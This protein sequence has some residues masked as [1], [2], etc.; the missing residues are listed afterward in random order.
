MLKTDELK[1]LYRGLSGGSALDIAELN[2]RNFRFVETS[3]EDSPEYQLFSSEVN[4]LDLSINA[5]EN[6]LMYADLEHEGRGIS[7]FQIDMPR[8]Y[9]RL[10]G[11]NNPRDLFSYTEMAEDERGL[12]ESILKGSQDTFR[13]R[14]DDNI[15]REMF[16][17]LEFISLFSY[18]EAFLESVYCHRIEPNQDEAKASKFIQGKTIVEA[19]LQ[20]ASAIHPDVLEILQTLF[21]DFLL[22]L[23]YCYL[24]RNFHTHNLGKM[25]ARNLKQGLEYGSITR[26]IEE[27][28]GKQIEV[29]VANYYPYSGRELKLG[30]YVSLTGPVGLLRVLCKESSFVLN[31]AI[32]VNPT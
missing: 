10:P 15:V 24:V 19:F 28:D 3:E 22:R 6:L 23:H 12:I 8:E 21:P 16:H 25:G 30:T 4:R 27:R 31:Q 11:T 7:D 13:L 1:E 9:F 29:Y 26:Q 18:F 20:I 5:V 2:I 32:K 14:N 17:R